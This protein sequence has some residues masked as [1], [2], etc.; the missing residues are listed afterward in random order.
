[1]YKDKIRTMVR[2]ILPSKRR[3]SAKKEKRQHHRDH[4]RA[5]KAA[6]YHYDHYED[7]DQ[8]DESPM[9]LQMKTADLNYNREIS[10]M[11]RERRDADKVNHFV[12]WAEDS[13]EEFPDIREK[14]YQFVSLVGGK[15]HVIKDHAIGHFIDP[16][17]DFRY[18]ELRT[19]R[20]RNQKNRRPVPKATF[21]A[22]VIQAI[23]A[24]MEEALNESLRKSI[25]TPGRCKPG[26]PCY[27]VETVSYTNLLWKLN[28][29]GTRERIYGYLED[30]KAAIPEKD[31]IKYT[32]SRKTSYHQ[33][34]KCGNIVQFHGV[35]TA[36][37]VVDILYLW[38]KMYTL[39]RLWG[40]MGEKEPNDYL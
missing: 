11:V 23:E 25:A 12:R 40:L 8:I 10:S 2:S 38:P 30:P 17:Y 21:L 18:E 36:K 29:D 7:R 16:R 19:R 5:V 34:E 1:M 4:R 14:H 15:G 33:A 37:R 28:P 22:R 26:S 9:L 31:I 13:T 35:K 20:Y 24:G 32:V 39:S 27:R 3:T 6:L